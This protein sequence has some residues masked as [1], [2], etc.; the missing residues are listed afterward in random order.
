VCLG[1]VHEKGI[2]NLNQGSAFVSS[3]GF[4][5]FAQP[6]TTVLSASFGIFFSFDFHNNNDA[7]L[8]VSSTY[9]PIKCGSCG[10]ATCM[11]TC[12]GIL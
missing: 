11:Y 5:L 6:D 7:L 8:F 3:F 2:W 9:S 4:R 12:L 10:L 1:R